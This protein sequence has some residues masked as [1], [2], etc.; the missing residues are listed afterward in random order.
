QRALRPTILL[1]ISLFFYAWGEKGYVLLMIAS[2]IVNYFL[3]LFVEAWRERRLGWLVL[4]LGVVANVLLLG[5]FKYAN[6]FVDNVNSVL[7]NF[8]ESTRVYVKHV[9]LPIGISFF[10]FEAIAY[11]V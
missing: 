8:D 11:L 3:G 2:I 5:Y 10:T 6:F 7:S 4:T 1:A 9:H